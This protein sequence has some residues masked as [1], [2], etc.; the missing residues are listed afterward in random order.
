MKCLRILVL[1]ADVQS[2]SAVP[3]TFSTIIRTTRHSAFPSS[4]AVAFII[5]T[6]LCTLVALAAM[7]F[8]VIVYC[9]KH[10][11]FCF[12]KTFFVELMSS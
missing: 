1:A 7:T 3:S 2:T 12:R 9:M 11:L 6:A 4:A 8:F 5:V 10:P